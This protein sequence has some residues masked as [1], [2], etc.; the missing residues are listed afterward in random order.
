MRLMNTTWLKELL[1][2]HQPPCVSIY[3]PLYR[4]DP[5][6]HENPRRFREQ[7]EHA[8]DSLARLYPTRDVRAMVEK[9]RSVADDSSFWVG[10]RDA[11]A[12]FASP[13]LLRVIDLQRPVDPAVYVADSFHVKPLIRVMQSAQQYHVLTVTQRRVQMFLGTGDLRLEPLDS[14]NIPQ[15]PD[16]VSKMRLSHAITANA[17]LRTPD[18]QYPG[19]GTAPGMS[20]LDAFMRAVDKAVWENFSR[21]ARLPLVLCADIESHTMFRTVS[22]NTHLLE[23]GI[24]LD[25]A[26]IDRERLKKEAW[27]LLEPRFRAE[28]EKLK[29]QFMAA[30][31]HEKGSDDLDKVAEAVRFGR[32]GTLLVDGSRT[33]AGRVDLDSGKVNPGDINDPDTDDV[34][35]DLAEMVLKTDGD[36]LVLPPDMMPSDAGL[37]A[38]YRY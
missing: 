2:E 32:V 12:V 13:D 37:A 34:L 1:A 29:D 11:L 19:E 28:V 3:T 6:G 27:A 36:V 10:D 15:S 7:V 24:R 30:Q 31:A 4:A 38:I 35:D 25:P 33:I 16:V 23:D 5:P 9:L 22:K 21:D 14:S 18:S 26:G 20:T 8:Q 17:D